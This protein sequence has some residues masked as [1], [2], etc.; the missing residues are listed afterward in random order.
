M[1]QA[2]SQIELDSDLFA[3]LCRIRVTVIN[4]SA[5]LA[6]VRINGN[7]LIVTD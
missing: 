6:P 7:E 4:H 1:I 2:L 3:Q 5:S